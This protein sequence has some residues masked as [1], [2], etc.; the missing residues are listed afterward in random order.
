MSRSATAIEYMIID[1]LIA[2]EPV[3]KITEDVFKPER[4]L[5]LTDHI[6]SRIEASEDPVCDNHPL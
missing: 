4:F 3:L 2:A 5:H 1:A 6:M